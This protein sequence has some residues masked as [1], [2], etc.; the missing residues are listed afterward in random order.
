MHRRRR[1]LKVL[2]ANKAARRHFGQKNKRTGEL[3]FSD[4]P[5]VLGAKIYQVLKNRRGDGPLSLRTGQFAGHGLQRQCRAVPAG[6]FHRAHFRLA[7]RR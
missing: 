2:H 7:D 4:L 5:Q 3:E 1:D 6:K